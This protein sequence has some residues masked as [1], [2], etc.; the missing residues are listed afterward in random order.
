MPYEDSAAMLV[1]SCTPTERISCF[2]AGNKHRIRFDRLSL[3]PLKGGGTY[4]ICT[5]NEVVDNTL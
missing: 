4:I 5:G 1:S 3:T 2:L